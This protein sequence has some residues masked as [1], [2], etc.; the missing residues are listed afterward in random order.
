MFSQ[1]RE[2]HDFTKSHINEVNYVQILLN[3]SCFFT[4]KGDSDAGFS[5]TPCMNPVPENGEKK[6]PGI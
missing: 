5:R 6:P 3:S 4:V 1:E 2:N